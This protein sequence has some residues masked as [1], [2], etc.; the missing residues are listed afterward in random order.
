MKLLLSLHSSVSCYFWCLPE[1]SGEAR[2]QGE[3]GA[4]VWAG[5]KANV[6]AA[7]GGSCTEPSLRS[8]CP[9][10]AAWEASSNGELS[11]L[12]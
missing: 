1:G 8:R 2:G 7:S 5:F 6:Q 11:K 10:A 12:Q 4:V 3:A 9:R